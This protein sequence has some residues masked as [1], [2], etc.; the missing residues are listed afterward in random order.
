M[1]YQEPHTEFFLWEKSVSKVVS[2]RYSEKCVQETT[3][4]LS[5]LVPRDLVQGKRN[6]G[7]DVA[8]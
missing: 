1:L 3:A 5:N 8:K 4:W 2:L 6:D 7:R